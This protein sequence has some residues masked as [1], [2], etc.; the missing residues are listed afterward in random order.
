MQKDITKTFEFIKAKF[1]GEGTGH[2]WWHI[3]RVWQDSIKIGKRENAD[4]FVVEMAALLHDL[5]DY[6]FHE[7][8]I[9]EKM[10]RKWLNQL[11]LDK[12]LTKKIVEVIEGVSFKGAQQKDRFRTIESKV[13]AD[14]DRLDAMGAIGIARAFAYG[15]SVG[16][17]LFDQKI[18]PILHKDFEHYKKYGN[19]ST[20]NHFYEKLFLLKDRMNTTM[21]QKIAK[22]RHKFMEDYLT[23][24]YDEWNGRA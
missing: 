9:G 22:S 16:R 10:V 6:K 23:R 4:L 24:F 5:E 2:D 17:P 3:Y 18:K 15:G 20:I 11:K 14:A 12:N 1:E 7:N 21:G 13:V 8:K 19:S